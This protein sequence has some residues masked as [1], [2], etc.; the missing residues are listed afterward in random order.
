LGDARFVGRNADMI[1][2]NAGGGPDGADFPGAGTHDFKVPD[3][4]WIAE[5]DAFAA[6]AVAVFF[7]KFPD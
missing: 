3:F 6:V 1:I 5:G 4:F 7:D 2:G